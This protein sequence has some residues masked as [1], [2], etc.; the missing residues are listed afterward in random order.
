MS[1]GRSNRL[2][3]LIRGTI[4]GGRS[5][6]GDLSCDIAE[7]LSRELIHD[8]VDDEGQAIARK[9]NWI[10]RVLAVAIAIIASNITVAITVS[11]A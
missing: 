4:G 3:R 6:Y 10:S 5:P 11:I 1:G 8:A 2:G 9:A 7:R